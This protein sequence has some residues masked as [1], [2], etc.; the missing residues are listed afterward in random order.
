MNDFNEAF[1]LIGG[2]FG[3]VTLLLIL[4]TRLETSLISSDRPQKAQSP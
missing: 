1:V 4:L 2:I 3:A